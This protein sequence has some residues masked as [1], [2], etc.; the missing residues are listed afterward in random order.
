MH[1]KQQPMFKR[2]PKAY[3]VTSSVH[4]GRST[5]ADS[6]RNDNKMTKIILMKEIC[7]FLHPYP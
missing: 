6:Q 5:H 3:K 7:D 2:T 4:G 1:R